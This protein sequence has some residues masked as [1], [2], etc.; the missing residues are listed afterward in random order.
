MARSMRFQ[1]ALGAMQDDNFATVL[2]V[3][4]H[5]GDAHAEDARYETTLGLLSALKDDY[6]DALC[7]VMYEGRDDYLEGCPYAS[8]HV[9][10]EFAVTWDYLG[11]DSESYA[12]NVMAE[13][14]PLA[15]YLHRGAYMFG[16]MLD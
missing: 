8:D 4:S 6:V 10:D 9:A 15:E 14:V 2:K 13:K 5:V 12:R 7:V 16:I 1:R 3:V 11:M